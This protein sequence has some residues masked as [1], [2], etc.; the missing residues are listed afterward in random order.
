MLKIRWTASVQNCQHS[1]MNEVKRKATAKYFEQVLWN[2]ISKQN[3]FEDR[4]LNLRC[5]K[6]DK[7]G[8]VAVKSWDSEQLLMIRR[9]KKLREL[10]G[11]TED[12]KRPDHDKRRCHSQLA[13]SHHLPSLATHD[14]PLTTG[15]KTSLSVPSI[16]DNR[17][18]RS[19]PDLTT[20]FVL[21]NTR[22][23]SINLPAV[24]NVAVPK[25]RRSSHSAISRNTCLSDSEIN[26]KRK[27]TLTWN[28]PSI[29][30]HQRN[31]NI[32]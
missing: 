18:S 23:E 1:K 9:N 2:N 3:S 19:H 26:T 7:D 32:Y 17:L 22:K 28:K 30:L 11:S 25:V 20:D 21:Q 6:I 15:R 10:I 8:S 4:R 14:R 12:C 13:T 5:S 24:S 16:L 29:Q 31:N 27:R